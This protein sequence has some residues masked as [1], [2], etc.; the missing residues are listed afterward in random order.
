M[1]WTV[2]ESG[3]YLCD[4]KPS[5]RKAFLKN[6][7]GF[8]GGVTGGQRTRTW[9]HVAEMSGVPKCQIDE[10]KEC[11]DKAGVPTEWVVKGNSASPVWRSRQHRNEWMKAM[12]RYDRQGGYGDYC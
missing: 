6:K 12:G 4:G 7:A 9:P 3:K 1:K 2:T 10:A 11:C 5:S 8:E